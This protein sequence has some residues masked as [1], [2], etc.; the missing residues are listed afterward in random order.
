MTKLKLGEKIKGSSDG[1]PWISLERPSQAK[2]LALWHFLGTWNQTWLKECSQG[3][4]L[5]HPTVIICVS[6]NQSA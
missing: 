1:K 4:T 2:Q 5:K 6:R 3:G